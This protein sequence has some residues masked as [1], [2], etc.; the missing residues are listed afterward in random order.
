MKLNISPEHFEEIIK[1]G[2][3]LDVIFILKA[4][5][6]AIDLAPLCE[7]NNKILALSHFK[8][9]F[10]FREKTK[11]KHGLWA[12]TIIIRH[13]GQCRHR[14]VLLLSGFLSFCRL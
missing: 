11:P 9:Q 12:K 4:T 14:P 8:R 13:P 1:Q 6:E 10:S 3:G 7:R 5:E 2:Y